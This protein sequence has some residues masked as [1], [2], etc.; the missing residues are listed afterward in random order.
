MYSSF[1]SVQ[2]LVSLMKEYGIQDV[3]LSPGGS[4]IPL[5]HSIENDNF[6]SCYSVVDERSAAYFAMGV[7]Q[8]RNRPVACIC[9][10]GT[11]VCNYLP[12]I[13][14]AF[15]QNIPVLAI[16]ADKDPIYQGQLE[17][18]KIEQTQI[19]KGVVKKAVDL[20]Q[21]NDAEQEWLCNRLINE[22]MLALSHHG[23][24]PVHINIPIVGRTDIY[25][26]TRLPKERVIAV[27]DLSSSN[28][29][30]GDYQKKL[31]SGKRVMVVVGQNV[32][33]S[34]DDIQVLNS[35]YKRYN[36]I[37]AVE[38]LSNVI[39][40]G[41]VFTYPLTEM[42]NM[43]LLEKT[44]PDIVISLG[45]NLSAY[46]LTPF[47]RT[48]YKSIENWLVCENGI[49]RDAYKSLTAM[50]E[51]SISSFL[52]KLLAFE[53][54][55]KS[56]HTYHN[57]WKQELEKIKLPDFEFSNF[58][59]GK[60]LA[61]IIPENSLLHTAI[62]NSTRVMNYFP[63]AKGVRTYSNVG[64]LGIDGCFSTFAGQASVFKGL[65]FLLIG[66]LSFFYDMNAAGLRSIN[67]NIRIILL[68]N[69]GGSEFHFFMGREKIPSIDD[70][71]CAKHNNKAEGW[72]QSLGYKYYG[73]ST[74]EQFEN[75]IEEFGKQ[76]EMPLF[77]EV[78][79]DM[80]QDANRTKKIYA[81]NRK[82]DENAAPPMK[83]MVKSLIPEKQLRKVRKIYQTLRED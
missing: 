73:V 14:E 69:G 16:T 52:K 67:K 2:I 65:S 60:R 6:F 74:K 56:D 37:F 32:H 36:C 53:D 47:L 49:V 28:N 35:F 81:N 26:C 61:Q 70:Y 50:F 64:A 66:D 72:I 21:I 45:N 42:R 59:V 68:N 83:K 30:W 5:I 48:Y 62:L 19:F 39:C 9:T 10:S 57:A 55:K 58:Y 31:A 15:Y 82:E 4:D 12:G 13:T 51:C 44:K 3:V 27:I 38:H 18:Q 29:K 71:V 8:S 17:I 75:V 24:G 23:T 80:Q 1:R 77:M 20:P 43:A 79:T 40:E 25:N 54:D 33:F 63:L 11:A 46:G 41:C 7:A 76:S 34:G 78:F 22:A